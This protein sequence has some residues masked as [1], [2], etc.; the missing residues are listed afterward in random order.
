MANYLIN[1]RY[2]GLGDHLFWSHLPRE[3]KRHD[4]Q[5]K[6]YLSSRCSFRSWQTYE[7]VWARNPYIDGL[8]SDDE[9]E[10]YKPSFVFDGCH[11]MTS[12]SKAFFS[13]ATINTEPAPEIYYNLEGVY[14]PSFDVL[15]DLNYSSYVGGL[16]TID[17]IKIAEMHPQNSVFVNPSKGLAIILKEDQIYRPKSLFEYAKAIYNTKHF[18]CLASGGATLA[19]ALG[20][21]AKVFYGPYFNASL[22][23]HESNDNVLIE[24]KS[25]YRLILAEYLSYRNA[26]RRK[27]NF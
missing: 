9:Y 5:A 19:A 10:F 16:L 21:R 6:V 7:L 22:F 2:G 15:V 24:P 3:I 26:L 18:S 8:A 14:S 27:K 17:M 23:L 11:V 20:V 13:A 1:P 4:D 25:K 12:L